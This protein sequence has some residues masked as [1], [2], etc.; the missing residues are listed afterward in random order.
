MSNAFDIQ[1]AV[2]RI[3]GVKPKRILGRIGMSSKFKITLKL[4]G[5]E[6]QVEGSRED[7]P[8]LTKN[9]SAQLAGMLMPATNMVEGHAPVLP[10]TRGQTS[11]YDHRGCGR[12]H[13]LPRPT[14]KTT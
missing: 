7:I 6:L 2:S 4:Q 14:G 10:P 9:V 12:I 1:I 8:M 13:T 5:F 3:S 11:L